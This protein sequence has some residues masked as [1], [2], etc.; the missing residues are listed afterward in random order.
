MSVAPDMGIGLDAGEVLFGESVVAA[1][2]K[3]G[4]EFDAKSITVRDEDFE[5]GV[6]KFVHSDGYG[7]ISREGKPDVYFH[8]ARVPEEVANQLED[9]TKVLVAVGQGRKGPA[10]LM[11]KLPD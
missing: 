5:P 8:V 10:A 3:A 6:V 11:V 7:F 4:K 9:G 1:H 2:N